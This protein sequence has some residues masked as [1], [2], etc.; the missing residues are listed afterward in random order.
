MAEVRKSA[1]QAAARKRA[2]EKAA[3]F[4][5]EQDTLEQL[6]VD[7][8]VAADAQDVIRDE[9][10]EELA[11]VRARGDKRLAEAKAG[12]DIVIANMLTL[13]ITRSEVAD[14]L[15]IPTRDVKKPAV[16]ADASDTVPSDG[17]ATGVETAA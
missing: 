6:A 11:A 12:A 9:V 16:T 14:R 3:A 5:E 10:E 15:G 4:R 13:G 1:T 8:F 2:R 7:F 17:G